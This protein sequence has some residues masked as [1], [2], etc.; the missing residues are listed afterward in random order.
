MTFSLVLKANG[1][2]QSGLAGVFFFTSGLLTAHALPAPEACRGPCRACGHGADG[3]EP[4]HSLRL[5]ELYIYNI[6]ILCSIEYH[7]ILHSIAFNVKDISGA[8]LRQLLLSRG[9]PESCLCCPQPFGSDEAAAGA[10]REPL[11][12]GAQL[13]SNLLARG[14]ED[15][16]QCCEPLQRLVRRASEDLSLN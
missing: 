13:L 3:P 14:L 6:Y 11:A 15:S 16:R 7:V 10:A 12:H 1:L 9:A 8:E 2:C 4:G 5:G